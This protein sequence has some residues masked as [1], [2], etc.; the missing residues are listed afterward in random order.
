MTRKVL[1]K[2]RWFIYLL[3]CVRTSVYP[4]NVCKLCRGFRITICIAKSSGKVRC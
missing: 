4:E 2:N 1:W 3:L